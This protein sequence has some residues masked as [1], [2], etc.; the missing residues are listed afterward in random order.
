[1]LSETIQT[2]KDIYY[3]IPHVESKNKQK[4]QN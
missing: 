2:K 3:I 4:K 1:M